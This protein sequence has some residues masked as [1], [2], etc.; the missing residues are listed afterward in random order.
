MCL[1]N[2]A[3]TGIYNVGKLRNIVM[4]GVGK[5]FDSYP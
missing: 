5:V 3:I 4:D 2:G 1:I